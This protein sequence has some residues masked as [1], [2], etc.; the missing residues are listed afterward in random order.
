MSKEMKW[1]YDKMPTE[2]DSIWANKVGT[3]YFNA[4]TMWEKCSDRVLATIEHKN[5]RVTTV[6]VTHDGKWMCD[7]LRIH[8][9]AKVVAWM[10]FPEPYLFDFSTI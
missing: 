8:S 1:I 2:K 9:D 4:S 3:Q 7:Y 5:Q 10:P 6:A